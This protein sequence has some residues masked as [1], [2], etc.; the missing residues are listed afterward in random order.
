MDVIFF[1]M[2]FL[3]RKDWKFVWVDDY[4]DDDMMSIILIVFLLDFGGVLEIEEVGF[5][6]S[7]LME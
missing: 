6:E 7:I 3:G 4:I 1:I 2:W 5:D